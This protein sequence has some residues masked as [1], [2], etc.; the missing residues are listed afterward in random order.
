MGKPSIDDTLTIDADTNLAKEQQWLH[1]KVLRVD[2]TYQRPVD[3]VRVR[4][5]ARN[6]DIDALGT[7][8]VSRRR[9]GSFFIIDGQHRIATMF[10]IGWSDQKV[11][12]L[13]HFGLSVE[14][15]ARIYRLRND[16]VRPNSFAIFRAGLT[17]GNAECID[18]DRTVRHCGLQIATGGNRGNVQA[19]S[20]LTKVYRNAGG[21]V[22]ERTLRCITS[23]WGTQSSNFQADILI[24]VGLVLNRLGD[25][26]D[27]DRLAAVLA[28]VT[29][30]S[31]LAQAR[32]TKIAISTGTG[33]IG[34]TVLPEIIVNLY[35]KGL[36]KNKL[37][38]WERR[39]N[40][41]EVWK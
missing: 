34:L 23:A 28:T 6:F 36:R 4:R 39:T 16:A 35:N 18:I 17:E 21:L 8:E 32:S 26:V 29:P 5:M 12:C 41:R 27:R 25:T 19:V 22:L 37:P 7:I 9:D 2:P 14:D 40:V 15:E 24:S 30:T 3:Q 33:S 38:D 20:A 10:E 31:L 1:V 13:V 11:P